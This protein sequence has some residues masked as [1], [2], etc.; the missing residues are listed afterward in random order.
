M[1]ISFLVLWASQEK[2]HLL[3]VREKIYILDFVVSSPF[4]NT[5]ICTWRIH[6]KLI[7]VCAVFGTRT[8]PSPMMRHPLFHYHKSDSKKSA[9]PRIYV[10]GR[11]CD[12]SLFDMC[13]SAPEILLPSHELVQLC[14][15]Q[16][17]DTAVS[18][19]VNYTVCWVG[20]GVLTACI[21]GCCSSF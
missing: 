19:D 7:G 10:R 16:T 5:S 12:R 18:V 3:Q 15:K 2:C 8:E 13:F 9:P 17:P 4:L 11:M 14:G 20:G 21:C 1:V 6:D